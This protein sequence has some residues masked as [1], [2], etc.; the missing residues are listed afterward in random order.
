MGL[1]HLWPGTETGAAHRTDRVAG[2]RPGVSKL[3]HTASPRR[4][5][6]ISININAVATSPMQAT[7]RTK[8]LRHL[9]PPVLTPQLTTAVS[10]ISTRLYA[11]DLGVFI[12]RLVEA[13][14]TA[15]RPEHK[16]RFGQ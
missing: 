9:P 8:L 7:G 14:D 3:P 13:G 15:S 16:G 2:F 5:A 6:G 10:I 11:F 4:I 12:A 1:T